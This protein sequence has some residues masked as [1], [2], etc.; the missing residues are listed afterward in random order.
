MKILFMGTPEFAAVNL[1]AIVDKHD[2]VAVV[3]QP[4]RP[5]GRGKNMQF[6]PVKECALA[7]N[8]PV[9]QP[10]NVSVP[11]V[12]DELRAYEPELIVVVAFGQFV[13]KK[14]R[15]IYEVKQKVLFHIALVGSIIITVGISVYYSYFNDF[16]PQGRYC[17]PMWIPLAVFITAGL[18]GIIRLFPEKARKPLVMAVCLMY[19]AIAMNAT[20]QVI[21][22]TYY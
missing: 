19:F 7:H 13:T 3:S 10:V 20:Y 4:D 5:K 1:K 18:S 8:I 21:A 15:E 22:V 11:E 12:I 6:S 16:Q 14:I 9:M 2:V 17:L